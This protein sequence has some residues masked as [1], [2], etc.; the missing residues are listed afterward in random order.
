LASEGGAA[1]EWARLVTSLAVL[2]DEAGAREALAQARAAH[3]GDAG[4]LSMLDGAASQAG[5]DP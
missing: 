2:G 3:E 4:A 5:L 1:P